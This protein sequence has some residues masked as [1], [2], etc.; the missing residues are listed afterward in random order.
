[1]KLTL[2]V[3]EQKLKVSPW[4]SASTSLTSPCIVASTNKFFWSIFQKFGYFSEFFNQNYLIVRIFFL[5]LFLYVSLVFFQIMWNFSKFVKILNL[6]SIFPDLGYFFRILPKKGGNWVR[7]FPLTMC[8]HAYHHQRHLWWPRWLDG[9]T[10]CGCWTS[11]RCWRS[12]ST[13]RW[14][15]RRRRNQWNRMEAVKPNE[16]SRKAS[17]SPPWFKL[18]MLHLLLT[19]SHLEGKKSFPRKLFIIKSGLTTKISAGIFF[20]LERNEN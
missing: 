12:G 14:W 2:T 15:R 16:L 17:K 6:Q 20:L 8:N 13:A 11:I 4:K 7:R 18:C 1:M 19:H 5:L 10:I 3:G 9:V